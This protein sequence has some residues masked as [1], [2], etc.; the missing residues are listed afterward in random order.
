M[1]RAPGL[2]ASVLRSR[3]GVGLHGAGVDVYR[4]P[5]MDFGSIQ[6]VAVLPFANLARDQ[7][8]AERVRDVFINRLLSTEAVYVLPVGEVARGIAKLE[9]QN[10]SSPSPEDVVKLGAFLKADAVIT[11][12]V[13]EYGE[14]RSGTTTANIISM[15]IQLIE[16]GT[17]Q[18]RLERLVHEGRHQL[19]EPA[20][21][22]R[23]PAAEQGDRA[24]G[25]RAVR[26]AARSPVRKDGRSAV[27]PPAFA[28]LIYL[29]FFLSGAAALVY[30]V[31]W[32]RSLTL[33]FGGSHLAVTAVLSIFMG[34]LAIGGYVVGRRVDRVAN[35]FASTACSSSGIAASALLFAGLMSN[36]PVDLCRA[37]PGHD[38]ATI[39]LRWSA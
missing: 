38:D 28:G 27:M 34:G 33:V 23:R 9:I 17:G 13:R 16:A 14:V 21:R 15:S 12:V 4:D 6:T 10:P 2:V 20:V 25:G 19:L 7:V 11:G 26:Q 32:V 35:R 36:L 1:R 5:N 39:Y 22:R 29:L 37:G 8:V 30:Q 31:V 3:L 18:D 24:G